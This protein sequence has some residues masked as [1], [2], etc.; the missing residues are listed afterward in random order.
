MTRMTL[1][2]ASAF[3]AFAG[4]LLA[5]GPTIIGTDPVPAATPAPASGVDWSGPYAGLS[6]GRATSTLDLP[7]FGEFDFDDGRV[8]GAFLGY[9]LQRGKLV[10]GGELSYGSV[11][12][13][14][15]NDP[16]LGG[17]D[18]IDSLMGL[19]GRVGYTLGNAL[20]YGA[21]GLSKG[22]MTFN[23]IDKPTVSGTSFALGMDYQFTDQIFVG[24]DYS[25]LKLD[26]T[27]DNPSNAFEIIAPV[28]VVSLRVGLSF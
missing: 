25:R 23:G 20:I 7:A 9:N 3:L 2:T 22:S 19:R 11:A 27:N 12:G 17:D 10:Y 13:M 8:T 26:G 5:G 6:Y 15:L 16:D 24:L 21:V 14:V 1:V 4:P 18:T 28:S